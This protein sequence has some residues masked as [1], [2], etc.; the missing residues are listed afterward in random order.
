M[1]TTLQFSRFMSKSSLSNYI[2]FQNQFEDTLGWMGHEER[3]ILMLFPLTCI[4]FVPLTLKGWQ[5]KQWPGKQNKSMN[6]CH[7]LSIDCIQGKEANR[8]FCKMSHYPFKRSYHH[9]FF[10]YN[11]FAICDLCNRNM[12]LSFWNHTEPLSQCA[13]V[14]EYIRPGIIVTGFQNT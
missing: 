8:S 5:L 2:H 14:Y 7:T 6:C 12:A 1:G 13:M 10:S 11:H 4:G 3:K 9:H